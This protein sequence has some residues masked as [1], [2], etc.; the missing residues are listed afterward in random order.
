MRLLL[1]HN[2]YQQSGGEDQS[3]NAEL[4]ALRGAGHEVHE[5]RVHNDSIV[6]RSKLK[7][8]METVWSQPSF[9]AIGEI[10]REV[11]PDLV[12][13][14]NTFP[15]ISP[16]AYYAVRDEGVPVIQSIR[17]YR[18]L[19]TNGLFYRDEKVCERC[20]GKRFAWPGVVH[21]CYRGSRLASLTVAAMVGAH[22]AM[23]TWDRAVDRYITLTDFARMKLVEGGLPAERIVVKPNFVHPDPG[24]GSGQGGYAIFV[25]RLSREKGIDTMLE[26]W[27]R[28]GDRIELHI[29]GDGPEA[30]RFEEMSRTIRGV[31]LLGRRTPAETYELI[32][33]AKLLVFPSEWYETFGRVA[34]E[35]FAKGTPVVASRIGAIAEVV[36][37]ERT[38]LLF[39]PG[40]CE[41]LRSAVELLLDHP[42]K[43]EAMRQ[44]VRREY[45]I[46]YTA[47]RNVKLLESI[48]ADVL[49]ARPGTSVHAPTGLAASASGP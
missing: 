11:R 46:K 15:L 29:V 14:N 6:G 43:C 12:H 33:Q 32:G 40:S 7:V 30:A 27:R 41:A 49:A 31:R 38:G 19:C 5:Y 10:V 9:E 23:G 16:S 45:E 25:G 4:A 34:I 28:L 35:A 13:F 44:T 42:E 26:A 37:H 36:E 24:M 20:M 2:A 8:A 18:L 47:A 1:A 22:R 17:N 3:F 21:G 48:Y 39:E